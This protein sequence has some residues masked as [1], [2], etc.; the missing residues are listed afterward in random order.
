V[1]TKPE[2]HPVEVESLKIADDPYVD[3]RSRPVGKY[4]ALFQKLKPGQ[5]VVCPPE[6]APNVKSAMDKWLKATG[7]EGSARARS[8]YPADNMGR[9]WWLLEG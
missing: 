4:D 1:A 5:C 6:R 7:R 8:R 2:R 3:H 9:V